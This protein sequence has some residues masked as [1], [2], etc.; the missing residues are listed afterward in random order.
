VAPE[1]DY[2]S[3]SIKTADVVLGDYFFMTADANKEYTVL[4]VE[5]D[6]ANR[7][8]FQQV[9][10]MKGFNVLT[11]PTGMDGFALATEQKPDVVVLDIA[12]PDV[13]G[14]EVLRL[15]RNEEKTKD[16]PVIATTAFA[17]AHDAERFL[18]EG[19]NFYISKPIDVSNFANQIRSVIA[20]PH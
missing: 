11:A 2:Q 12:L 4:V 9:L 18:G 20:Q 1:T 19:F 5:D 8:L 3:F 16:I 6:A 13:S 14:I 7:F 10:E 17:M 15:L